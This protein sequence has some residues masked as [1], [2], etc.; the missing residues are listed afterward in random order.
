VALDQR[1]DLAVVAAEQQVAFPVTR[2]GPILNR[3]WTLTD[4]TDKL[5]SVIE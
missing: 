2:Y 1:R 4:G 5:T 3:C